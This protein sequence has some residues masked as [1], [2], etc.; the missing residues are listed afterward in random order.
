MVDGGAGGGVRPSLVECG[1]IRT[2]ARETLPERLRVVHDGIAELIQRHHPDVVSVEG[3]FYARNVRSTIV[4]GHARGVI[5][6]AAAAAGLP[7]VEYS[8]AVV[9]RTV[10]GR[11]GAA[12]PQVGYMVAQ[13]LRLTCAPSPADAADAVAI[14]LTHLLKG[15]RMAGRA[16]GR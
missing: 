2:T 10:V 4:L 13:L 7:V 3:I 12:K 9:K 15:G 14:A 11:G 6:L 1:V 8:P 16:G 5:L